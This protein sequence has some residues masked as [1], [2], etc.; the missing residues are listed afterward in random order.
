MA[1]FQTS[2]SG[3]V[4]VM[5][6]ILLDRHLQSVA[7]YLILRWIIIIIF[8]IFILSQSSLSS[9]SYHKVKSS[10]IFIYLIVRNFKKH[11]SYSF[12]FQ[13]GSSWPFGGYSCDASW[14]GE[15]G[16]WLVRAGTLSS[17]WSDLPRLTEWCLIDLH[18]HQSSLLN[19][20][21]WV[22]QWVSQSVSHWQALP[23]I[24]LGIR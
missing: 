17:I 7:N 13:L 2:G 23:M 9:L 21:E 24:E 1:W 12:L 19:G 3:N 4:F 5:A 15:R 16:I 22:S 8:I 6:A 11:R 18:S 20:S 14:G 10:L